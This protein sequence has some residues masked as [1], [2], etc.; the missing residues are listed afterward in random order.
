MAYRAIFLIVYSNIYMREKE[1]AEAYGKALEQNYRQQLYYM[2]TLEDVIGRLKSERHDF[3][4]HLGV[5]YALLEDAE[6]DKARDYAATLVDAAKEY[7]TMVNI[8]YSMLRAMLN[9]K[10]SAA[11]ERGIAL[12]LDTSLPAGL[13]LNEADLTVILGNMMDNA[14]EACAQVEKGSRYIALNLSYK[15]DYLIIMAENPFSGDTAA[16][17]KRKTTK[18]DQNNHGF[19]LQNIEYLVQKHSGIMKLE[20]EP[21][22]FRISLALLVEA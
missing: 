6:N 22:I 18:P 14:M 8:P 10:L 12:K 13:N 5:M 3:N 21:G 20:P 7:R 4:H 19:G 1:R 2:E 11:K 9:Y 17:G 16:G 15:P